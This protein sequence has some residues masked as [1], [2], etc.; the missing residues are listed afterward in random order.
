MPQLSVSLECFIST[1]M[2]PFTRWKRLTTLID[3][4]FINS[5]SCSD[6][7]KKKLRH[8]KLHPVPYYHAKFQLPGT[9]PCPWM[10]LSMVTCDYCDIWSPSVTLGY[11]RPEMLIPGKTMPT[12]SSPIGCCDPLLIYQ[13]IP[14]QSWH[15]LCPV[16]DF[17]YTGD[18]VSVSAMFLMAFQTPTLR[19]QLSS[20]LVIACYNCNCS[21]F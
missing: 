15:H 5:I 7:I 11:Q 9:F 8:R 20:S 16:S 14:A 3:A 2:N 17:A 13:A 4:Y 6:P 1:G 18:L 19:H 10:T 12:H 21:T